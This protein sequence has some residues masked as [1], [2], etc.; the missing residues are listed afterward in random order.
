MKSNGELVLSYFYP[1]PHF[2]LCFIPFVS[3]SPIEDV[4]KRT[5][6]KIYLKEMEYE[7]AEWIHVAHDGNQWWA[8]EASG[9]I[10]DVE[11]LDQI[12]E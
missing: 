4:D 3:S 8:N 10:T 7:G 12:S 9:S 11:F 1:L 2:F 6:L 5:I